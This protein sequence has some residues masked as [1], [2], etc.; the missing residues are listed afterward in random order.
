MCNWYAAQGRCISCGQTFICG[1]SLLQCNVGGD[2]DVAIVGIVQPR[3]AVEIMLGHFGTGKVFVAQ[4]CY[5]FGN[6]ELMHANFSWILCNFLLEWLRLSRCYGCY[7][8][9]CGTRYKPSWVAGAIAWKALR[10]L[11][12]VTTSAR[13]R[14]TASRGWAI[15]STPSVFTACS[16]STSASTSEIL[17]AASSAASSVIWIRASLANL[18]ISERS[19]AMGY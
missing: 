1:S 18:A 14:C 19:T 12:S 7:S 4:T 5:Q 16:W 3:N 8:I 15:G 11:V 2:S 6:G 13:R 17:F 10:W 9:T